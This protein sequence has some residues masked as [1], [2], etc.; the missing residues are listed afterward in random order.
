MT[1]RPKLVFLGGVHGVG[2]STLS[3]ELAAALGGSAASAST[4]IKEARSGEVTWNSEKYVSGI[5]DN[6][7]LLVTA[8]ERRVREGLPFVLD[9]HFV[10]KNTA[11][12]I[13][14]LAVDVFKALAPELLV[15]LTD[16]PTNIIAR[17][18]QRDHV[19]H[20]AAALEEMQTAEKAH[21]QYLGKELGV[22]VVE[23]AVEDLANAVFRV[24]AALGEH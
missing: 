1:V 11:G 3:N 12:E 18:K 19:T 6:Q 17:L 21:A 9:G 4:L 16:N 24:K 20:D 22:D 8:V 14:R 5:Q 15:I 23:I 13:E 2:K 7:R 10:L